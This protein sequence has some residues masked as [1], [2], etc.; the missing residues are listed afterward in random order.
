MPGIRHARRIKLRFGW[1]LL[2]GR[3][4]TI[5]ITQLDK[6]N[7]TDFDLIT[8]FL[9]TYFPMGAIISGQKYT[10]DRL[11]TAVR[12]LLPGTIQLRA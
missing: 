1:I 7:S 6:Q 12:K 8:A 10:S 4:A 11:I 3:I 2:E 5:S 9:K